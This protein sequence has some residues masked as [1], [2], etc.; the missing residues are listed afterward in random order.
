M[1]LKLTADITGLKGL[2]NS[3]GRLGRVVLQTAASVQAHAQVAITSGPKTGRVYQRGEHQVEFSTKGGGAA[4]F[5]ANR[6]KAAREHQASA[7]GEAP[8]NEMGNLAG[9]ISHR[10]TGAMAAE[11]SVGAEQGPA[12]EF[13]REDGS[14]EKR[15]FLAPAVAAATEDFGAAIAAELRRAAEGN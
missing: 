8:A 6:G 2:K 13:G 5:T 9:S 10:M 7:P 3:R 12:L 1:G 11:V 15:P 4:S 14:I